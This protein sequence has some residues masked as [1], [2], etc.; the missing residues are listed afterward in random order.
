MG[1]KS[2]I[3]NQNFSFQSKESIMAFYMKRHLF[4][5]LYWHFMLKGYYHGPEFVRKI[6]NPMG[7]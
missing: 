4:P 5:F 7:W 3:T 2:D 1:R 6:V